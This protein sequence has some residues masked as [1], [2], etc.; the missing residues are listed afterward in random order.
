V[1]I[2]FTAISNCK[3]PLIENWHRRLRNSKAA[4]LGVTVN[5]P[6]GTVSGAEGPPPL[7][8]TVVGHADGVQLVSSEHLVEH[9]PLTSRKHGGIS[10]DDRG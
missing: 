7:P 3:Q 4:I 5:C 2:E 6:T 10:G 8:E 9:W 1:K